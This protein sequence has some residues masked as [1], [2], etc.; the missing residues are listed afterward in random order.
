MFRIQP[1]FRPEK[2]CWNTENRFFTVDYPEDF[3]LVESLLNAIR[4]WAN[5]YDFPLEKLFLTKPTLVDIN[6]HLHE[7]FDELEA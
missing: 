1:V 5:G 2:K 7:P 6:A 3:A 4:P